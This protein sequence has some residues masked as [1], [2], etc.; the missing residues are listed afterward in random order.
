MAYRFVGHFFLHERFAKKNGW[1][2]S[3]SA[4]VLFSALNKYVLE[5]KDTIERLERDIN[6]GKVVAAVVE[7]GELG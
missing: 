2:K 7:F 3:P 5:R 6:R 4:N 1:W